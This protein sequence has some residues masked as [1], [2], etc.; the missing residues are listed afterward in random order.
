VTEI[1]RG[2]KNLAKELDVPLI[3]V[4]QLNRAV[5]RAQETPFLCGEGGRGWKADF[6]W[7]IANDRNMIR[8]LEGR[9]DSGARAGPGNG[10]ATVF[11]K[12]RK[13]RQEINHGSD[14]VA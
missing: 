2:L 5:I 8:G 4:S 9:C 6:D 14:R 7:L 3:A 13:E 12:I 11:D 1:S 10:G